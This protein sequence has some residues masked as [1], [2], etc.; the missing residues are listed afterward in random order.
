[1]MKIETPSDEIDRV[2]EKVKDVAPS[3][4]VPEEELLFYKEIIAKMKG[5]IYIN[6]IDDIDDFTTAR[7]IWANKNCL[8]SM[9]YTLEEVR[10]KGYKLF[11]ETIHP[12]DAGIAQ[13]SIDY[14]S[15]K[16][17]DVFGG[18]ARFI[19]KSKE[20]KW[21][22]GTNVVLNTRNGKPWQFLNVVL[23]IQ[24]ELHAQKQ[25]LE[26]QCEN[27]RLKNAL[28]VKLLSIREKSVLKHIAKGYSHKEIADKLMISTHT[29]RTHHRNISRKLGK[30]K[31]TELA[32]FASESGLI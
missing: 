27:I 9:G 17:G 26:L 23:N 13:Q 25:L 14:H 32:V 18:L 31:I 22:F 3:G 19:N 30:M 21:Y 7:M 12:D 16:Q 2:F 28:Q 24:D 20:I 10:E 11:T 8:E 6:Q 15:L 29:A 4:L 5:N 1:M